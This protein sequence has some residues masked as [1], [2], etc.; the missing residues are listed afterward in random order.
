MDWQKRIL[1]TEKEGETGFWVKENHC[2]VDK[3]LDDDEFLFKQKLG[4]CNCLFLNLFYKSF[5]F[6]I[7]C[8]H[9]QLFG[10][11]VEERCR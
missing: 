3:P 8:D 9:E 7:N 5:P 2:R 1:E 4:S 6:K 11:N 10:N